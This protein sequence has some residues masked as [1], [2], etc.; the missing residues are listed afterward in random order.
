[1]GKKKKRVD[2]GNNCVGF[3]FAREAMLARYV[4]ALHTHSNLC[5]LSVCQKRCSVETA[6][7]LKYADCNPR[8]QQQEQR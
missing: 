1:M 3:F 4:L 8:G 5:R 2:E 6:V 7:M